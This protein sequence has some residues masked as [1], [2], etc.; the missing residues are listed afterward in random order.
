MADNKRGDKSVY[1]ANREP[2][3]LA[4]DLL[5]R[6]K[7]FY[8][9]LGKNDYLLKVADNWRFYYGLFQDS[10]YL[11]HKVGY[12]GEQGELVTLPVNEFRNI[13][14]HIYVMITA[15]RP[16]M[17][18]RAINT[19]A[20]SLSQ[21]YL[22]N[23]ILD[24]YMRER[25]LEDAL[26]SCTEMAVVLGSGFIKMEWNAMAG[27]PYDFDE[28]TGAYNYQGDVEFTNLS[29]F[30]VVYDGT[31]EQYDP[32]WVLV[33][34]FKNRYDLMAKYPEL[35]E[36]IHGVSTKDDGR[37]YRLSVWSNDDTDDIAVYEFFH[38]RTESVPDGKYSLFVAEDITLMTMPLPYRALP[39][40]R[41]T[42]GNIMGTPYGYTPLFDIYPL[43]EALNSLFSTFM[44][45][46]NAFGVQS[47]F[48]PRGSDISMASLEGGL[49]VIQGNE[50]PIPIQLSSTP[51]E[52]FEAI[53]LIREEIETI[54]G[55]SSVTR[56]QPEASLK[57]G[58]ALALVQSMSLQ[59]ISGL[60]QSYVK[61]IESVGTQLINNLK[62]FAKAPRIAAI[63]GK[64]NKTLLKEFSGEDLT[65]INRVVVDVGNPLA[66]TTAGRVQMAEQMLQMN[67]LK[68]P[69]EYFQVIN[70]GKLDSAFEGDLHELFLIK[71]EN[72]KMMEGHS[73]LVSPIDQH[74]VHINE[75]RGVLA[76]SDIRENP[77]LVRV[78]MDHIAKHMDAL[79]NTDP[80]LLQLVGEQPLNPIPQPLGT[81]NPAIP[82]GGPQGSYSA[83]ETM[84][85]QPGLPQ[86]GEKLNTGE[87]VAT[88]ASPPSPFETLPTD[89]RNFNQ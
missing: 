6:A 60:Q 31:R 18:A 40:F 7:S 13:A 84:Q 88:P 1:F 85:Q 50:P 70:T 11:G 5:H 14:Q 19:D 9:M 38:K 76:D 46:L 29:P 66:K 86:P 49:N 72:E 78:V 30:D 32:D 87:S 83:S 42:P 48:V 44:T 15:N 17:E 47:I 37:Q 36:K 89:P 53:K 77:E 52:L 39:V 33:R 57:S 65:A 80:E 82:P 51:P 67:L 63:V 62:D 16:T 25:N 55:I 61:L 56:G 81:T 35:A 28:E 75:H 34:S 24:Y 74:R 27:E 54:S 58:N 71:Q 12:T 4:S 21:A 26:K 22:A 41:M 2:N 45:N 79:R 73:P 69:Q 64:Y 23:G 43:Q 68:T 3:E 8:N 20:K 10:M 59:F